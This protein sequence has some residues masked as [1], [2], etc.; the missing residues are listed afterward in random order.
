[1]FEWKKSLSE[2]DN[3]VNGMIASYINSKMQPWSVKEGFKTF[4]QKWLKKFELQDILDAIDI[5]A[6]KY[7]RFEDGDAT[8]ESAE[9]YLNK[10]GGILHNKNLSPIQQKLSYIKGIARNRF[11]YWDDRKGSIILSNYIQ[12]LKKHWNDERILDD[13]NKE[14]EVETKNAN[15]WTQWR[16]RIEDWTDDINEKWGKPE[17]DEVLNDEQATSVVAKSAVGIKISRRKIW[18][19]LFLALMPSKMSISKH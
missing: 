6:S 16:D 7:L 4:I 15:N 19:A 14:V 12:A 3:E 13:L 1:M 8:D 10:I 9:D 2:L 5:S 18:R 11:N 17:N